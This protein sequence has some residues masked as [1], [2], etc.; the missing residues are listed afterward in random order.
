MT[1]KHKSKQASAKSKK[2]SVHKSTDSDPAAFHDELS[3]GP[4]KAVVL[5]LK[6]DYNDSFVPVTESKVLPKPLTEL[7][8]T[9]AMV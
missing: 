4:G 8:D 7:H 3:Q 2:L 1:A 5:S 9:T 6:A